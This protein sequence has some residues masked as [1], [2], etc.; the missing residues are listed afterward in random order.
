MPSCSHA[1]MLSCSHALMLLCSHAL[2]LTCSHSLVLYC[3]HAHMLL[4][5]HA[6]MLSCSHA[7]ILSCTHALMLSC[8]HAAAATA[9]SSM[10]SMLMLDASPASQRTGSVPGSAPHVGSF[11]QAAKSIAPNG[12]RMGTHFSQR[13][14]VTRVRVGRESPFA[15]LL[16]LLLLLGLLYLCDARTYAR[17]RAAR[18][19][20][21]LVR[22]SL[23]PCCW[24]PY[25]WCPCY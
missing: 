1:L 23:H 15:K 20:H 13:R 21:T 6:L 5:S 22:S 14:G 7:L 12:F 9:G 19:A 24:H 17:A 25:W 18:V 3:S 8:S 2:M 11:W 16:L 4:C 10:S